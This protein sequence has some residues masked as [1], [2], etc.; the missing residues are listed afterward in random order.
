MKT[1]VAWGLSVESVKACWDLSY[2]MPQKL[3]ILGK[4]DTEAYKRTRI[5]SEKVDMILLFESNPQAKL[6]G[7][8][9]VL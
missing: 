7:R 5:A 1:S 2:M 3:E 8:L 4:I 6:L 9:Y